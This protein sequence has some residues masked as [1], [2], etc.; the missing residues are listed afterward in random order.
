LQR[1]QRKE[2]YFILPHR[3][4][5]K[6]ILVVLVTYLANQHYKVWSYAIAHCSFS[7]VFNHIFFHK[8][9]TTSQILLR[10][11]YKSCK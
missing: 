11:M 4:L 10:F 1:K 7:V 6:N 3:V 8:L 9:E 5:Q 2:G